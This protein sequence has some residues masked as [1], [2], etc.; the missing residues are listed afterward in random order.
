MFRKVI[1]TFLLFILFLPRSFAMADLEIS[2]IMYD[3]KSGSDDG[4]EWV[5]VY[6]N[7][8]QAVDLSTYKF[9]EGDVNHKLTLV[10]GS[11]KTREGEYVVIVSDPIKFKKDWPSFVGNIFDSS[12]SL[13]NTGEYLAI[14]DVDK[15]ITEY[16]YN[17]SLGGAG[18]G[19]SL[20]KINDVWASSLPT[21]GSENK[22]VYTPLPAPV[23]KE[24]ITPKASSNLEKK[25]IEEEAT[26]L[27]DLPPTPALVNSS[28]L[29]QSSGGSYLF[30]IIFIGLL[31][32]AVGAVYFIR[33]KDKTLENED[34]FEL[35][36]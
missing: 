22:I 10:E 2:E 17:T 29:G 32:L 35:L 33:K 12:F 9:F 4:R 25:E 3:L 23:A 36:D 7:S 8:D 18:D 31:G 26:M 15:I 6:N 27:E 19:K 34:D 14:K 1:F 21:P 16:S 28:E 11:A 13:S 30:R 24:K 20:Q 5:E